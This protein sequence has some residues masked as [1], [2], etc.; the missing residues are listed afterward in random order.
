ML[1][2]YE[3]KVKFYFRSF[4]LPFHPWAMPGAIAAECAKM[5]KPEAYWTLYRRVLRRTRAR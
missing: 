5:Q 1:K 4:P 2:Q 3:G